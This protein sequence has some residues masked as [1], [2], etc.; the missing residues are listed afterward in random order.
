MWWDGLATAVCMGLWIAFTMGLYFA[1]GPWSPFRIFCIAIIF[2]AISAGIS[3]IQQKDEENRRNN[4][5]MD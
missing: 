2:I 3:H 1:G 5:Y 4:N